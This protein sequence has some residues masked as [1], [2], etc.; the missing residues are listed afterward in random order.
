MNLNNFFFIRKE[1]VVTVSCGGNILVNVGPDKTGLIQPIFAERLRD[2]G[3][4][5]S[6][7]GPA[8]YNS[9]PW[10]YQNDTSTPNVWYTSNSSSKH[11]RSNVYAIVLDYPYD[12]E[13]VELFSL[14]G[15]TD[16]NT[17][18]GI[19]GYTQTHL[20]WRITDNSVVVTF[21][22]KAQLDKRGLDF[23]WTVEIDVPNV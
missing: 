2:M 1:L 15:H 6:I 23:A 17:T 14:F 19:L 20:Q 13:S 21:P 10:I 4:W 16:E 18:I 7:N 5:L 8:I 3:R 11:L 12:D 9:Q 22:R